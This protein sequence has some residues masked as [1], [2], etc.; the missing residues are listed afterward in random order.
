[1]KRLMIAGLVTLASVAMVGC[2]SVGPA[3]PATNYGAN[4]AI[5]VG[6]LAVGMAAAAAF[7]FDPELP[8]ATRK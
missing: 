2:A 4:A 5:G 6:V 7:G 3:K 8:K 1:M